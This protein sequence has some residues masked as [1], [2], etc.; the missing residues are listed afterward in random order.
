MPTIS[1][2]AP[3][4]QSGAGV[5]PYDPTKEKNLGSEYYKAVQRDLQ[6]RYGTKGTGKNPP[7]KK[8]NKI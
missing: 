1:N 6:K 8:G 3:M 7:Y 5:G 2:G 4:G